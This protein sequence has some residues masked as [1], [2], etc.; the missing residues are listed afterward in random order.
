VDGP[1]LALVKGEREGTNMLTGFAAD[2]LLLLILIVAL[3]DLFAYSQARSLHL[4]LIA[5]AG[6]L[7]AIERHLARMNEKIP[8]TA[9]GGT[10]PGGC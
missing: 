5:I 8:P 6:H 7:E 4:R 3:T 10:A 9:A 1:F 2:A